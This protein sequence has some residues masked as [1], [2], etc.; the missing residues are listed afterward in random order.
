[1][2]ELKRSLI[3]HADR[4]E[5]MFQI[6]ENKLELIKENHLAHIQVSMSVLE[7][8]YSSL[9]TDVAWLKWGILAVIGGIIASFFK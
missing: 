7:N 8:K 6:I 3:E 2:E 5:K 1:M 9:V 4:D